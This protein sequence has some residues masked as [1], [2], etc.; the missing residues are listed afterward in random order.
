MKYMLLIWS[1]QENWDVVPEAEYAE[2]N[3]LDRS[4]L[5]SGELIM[6]AELADPVMTKAVQVHDGVAAT[7]DGPFLEAKE[8]LAG[9]FLVEC[10]SLERALAVAATI[11]AA[12]SD[13][14]RVEVR[15]VMDV[16]GLEM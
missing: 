13:R 4:L 15:P 2:Y 14:Q 10:E 9:Y 6:S 8:H 16:F 11:P 5:D 3:A 7:T 12:R 1:N